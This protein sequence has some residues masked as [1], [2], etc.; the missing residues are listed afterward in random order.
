MKK[1]S[2]LLLGLFVFASCLNNDDVPNY[3]FEFMPIDEAITPES[4]T[5]GESDT[6][7]IK[8]S[9][10]NDCYSFEQI[11]YE[12]KDSTRTVAVTAMVLLDE[13]CTEET[14]QEEKKFVVTASQT[15]D[16]IF[17]FFK[18]TDSEGENIFEEVIVPVN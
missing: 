7:T 5:Y 17:K 3:K 15:E 6:I 13:E 2:L 10:P 9:F 18:G 11:Y 4:F 12:T 1:I 14:V 8:Y 16:Y